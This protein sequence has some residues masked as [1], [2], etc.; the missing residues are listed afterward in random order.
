[1]RTTYYVLTGYALVGYVFMLVL[2][3]RVEHSQS[4]S[5]LP[6]FE[7]VVVS[8]VFMVTWPLL[9]CLKVWDRWHGR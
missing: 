4:L 1:M 7:R 3:R 5:S 8:L 2:D 6:W 9:I